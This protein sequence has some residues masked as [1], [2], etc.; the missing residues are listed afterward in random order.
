ER[1]GIRGDGCALAAILGERDLRAGGS[2][3]VDVLDALAAFEDAVD[4]GLGA[5]RLRSAGLDPARTHA[6]DRVA[7]Q[8]GRIADRGPRRSRPEPPDGAPA[9]DAARRIA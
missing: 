3:H 4:G 7:R 2:G 8:L 6:A 5:D 1:R 9:L